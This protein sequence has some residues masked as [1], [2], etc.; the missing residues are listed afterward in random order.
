MALIRTMFPGCAIRRSRCVRILAAFVT[1]P[2]PRS[3]KPMHER[4]ARVPAERSIEHCF[5]A[6]ETS[7]SLRRGFV[8]QRATRVAENLVATKSCRIWSTIHCDGERETGLH[9]R[10]CRG[11]TV[12]SR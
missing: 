6:A 11:N 10:D 4:A 3:V 1:L 5:R 8:F 2:V 9:A 12:G 7:M